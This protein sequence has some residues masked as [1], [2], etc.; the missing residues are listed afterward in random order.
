MCPW[1]RGIW[2]KCKKLRDKQKVHQYHT[3]NVLIRLQTEESGQAKIITHMVDLQN[4]FPDS[5]IDSLQLFFSL[6]S[7]GDSLCCAYFLESFVL[8]YIYLNTIFV[9]FFLPFLDF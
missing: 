3:I 5:E 8:L 2:N 1:Y 7:A 9:F 4:L 6:V